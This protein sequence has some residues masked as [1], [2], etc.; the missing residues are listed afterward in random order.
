MITSQ[1]RTLKAL[2][3]NYLLHDFQLLVKLI[4]CVCMRTWWSHILINMT[5]EIAYNKLCYQIEHHQYKGLPKVITNKYV[6][7]IIHCYVMR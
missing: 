2:K 3:K 4:K 7:W 1:I 6:Q 5:T